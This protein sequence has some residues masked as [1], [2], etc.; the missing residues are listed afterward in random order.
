MVRVATENCASQTCSRFELVVLGSY[1]AEQIAKGA[2]I[3]IEKFNDKSCVLA[4]REIAEK[5]Q[6]VDKLRQL[7]VKSLQCTNKVEEILS[8]EKSDSDEILSEEQ[9]NIGAEELIE[10]DFISVDEDSMSDFD[11]ESNKNLDDSET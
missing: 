10:S 8:E 6:D 9:A 11:P 1:R 2:P 7:Y 5:S 4:L 3:K